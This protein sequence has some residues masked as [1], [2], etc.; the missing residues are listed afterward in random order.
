M[1]GN[2]DSEQKVKKV[3]ILIR[4]LTTGGSESQVANLALGLRKK[5][6]FVTVCVFYAGGAAY[7]RLKRENIE[8]IDARKEGRW[9]FRAI[10]VL[11]RILREKKPDVLYGF[12]TESNLILVVWRL[13][14]YPGKIVWGIRAASIDKELRPNDLVVKIGFILARYFSKI[15]DM[16]VS[17][18]WASRRA[19]IDAG[20]SDRR[21]EV[22]SNGIDLDQFMVDKTLRVEVRSKWR[23]LT[24]EW[25]IGY[26]AR[27]DPIKDHQCFFQAAAILL[28]ESTAK[29]RFVV[30][31][32]GE[33]K[34]IEFLKDLVARLG[35]TQNV[36]W[37]GTEVNMVGVY[38]ALDISTSCSTSESFPNTLIE[39]MA[40]S[41]PCVATSVGDVKDIAQKNAYIVQPNDPL[42]VA[43]TWRRVMDKEAQGSPTGLDSRAY[44]SA[45]FSADQ[46]VTKTSSKLL[47]L[48]DQEP[49]C[50]EKYPGYRQ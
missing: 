5:G 26:V 19:H 8:L 36:L 35:I 16:I 11:F 45:R 38:N 47:M 43:E 25:A 48:L 12:L 13:L 44:V 28:A 9:D 50:S 18:S 39:A 42:S 15:P 33:E 27:L 6:W 20:F 46:M 14:R 40:C 17:N 23:L 30:V 7:D 29:V 22:I 3:A 37:T 4:S 10:G 32:E 24:D 21:F 49:L 31:G 34:Y 41:V 1:K 2:T